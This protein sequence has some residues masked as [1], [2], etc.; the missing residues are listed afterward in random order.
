MTE[1][2]GA[3]NVY[4]CRT[5]KGRIVTKNRQ[6]GTTPF[7]TGCHATPDCKGTMQSMGYRVN[8]DEVPTH[9]W[10]RPVTTGERRRWLRDPGT[11]EHVR[12]GGLVLREVMN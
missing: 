8:Q 5:C 1:A 10:F 7:M 12:M 2:A 9:E 3:V 11:A 6:E 4:V